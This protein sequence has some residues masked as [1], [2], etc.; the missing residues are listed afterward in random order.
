MDRDLQTNLGVALT[1]TGSWLLWI[2]YR[3]RPKPVWIRVAQLVG[4]VL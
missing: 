4:N 1:L 2:A 3:E